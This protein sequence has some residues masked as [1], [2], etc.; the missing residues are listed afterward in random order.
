MRRG[1]IAWRD[2]GEG[3]YVLNALK[4]NITHSISVNLINLD[5]LYPPTQVF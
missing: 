3:D 1:R 4:D 2:T 5:P